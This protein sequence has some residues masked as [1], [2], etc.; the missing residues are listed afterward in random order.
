M[1]EGPL[2]ESVSTFE[3]GAEAGRH[4][5]FGLKFLALLYLISLINELFR[6]SSPYVEHFIDFPWGGFIYF[7]TTAALL[8]GLLL[9][10]VVGALIHLEIE[11]IVERMQNK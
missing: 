7:S 2:K 9:S 1:T 11:G 8:S 3:K 6:R 4:L 10:V 5:C